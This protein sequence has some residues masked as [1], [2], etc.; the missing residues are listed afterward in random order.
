M[1]TKFSRHTKKDPSL[2]H[3]HADAF[4]DSR[5]KICP[6]CH[7][8]GFAAFLREEWIGGWDGE[9]VYAYYC[10]NCHHE[11]YESIHPSSDQLFYR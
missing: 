3:K 10:R 4:I 5:K 7:Q 2:H 9:K 6:F 8:A 1:A 11:A